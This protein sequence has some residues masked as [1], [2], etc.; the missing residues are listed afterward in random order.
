MKTYILSLLLS[1]LV[2]SI[3][4]AQ[5][6]KTANLMPVPQKVEWQGGKFRLKSDFELSVG[7]TYNPRLK[8]GA[9][10]FLRDLDKKTG[11]FFQQG[12]LSQDDLGKSTVFEISSGEVGEVNI[13]MKEDYLLEVTQNKITL[14][15]PTDIGAL[16]GLE[17]LLQLVSTDAEGYFFPTVKIDDKPRFKWRGLMIDVSRHFMPIQTIKRNIDLMAAVKLNV[18][19]W[20]L[21]DDQGFRIEVKAFPKL[22]ELGADG[23]YYT[24]EELKEIVAY[25]D[26]RGIRVVPEVD[27]P[28]HATTFAV[29]YPE[30][31]SSPHQYIHKKE[32]GLEGDSNKVKQYHIERN[33]G[34]F[35]AT[36]DPTN[37]KTYEILFALFEEMAEIFPDEYVHIGGDENEGKQ[38][39]SNKEIQKFMIEKGLKDN[40]DLQNHFNKK[41]LKKLQS[42]GKIMMGWD[43]I[44]QPDLP[45][46]AVIQSWRGKESLYKAASQGYQAVLSN[47]YYIDLMHSAE[48][49]YLNDP[50]SKAESLSDE[51]K[52][53]ILGG[54]ATMW[55]EHI[56]PHTI[57]SRIWPRMAAIAERY[58]SAAS[59]NDVNDMYR[60]LATIELFLESKG[61]THRAYQQR[62]IRELANGGNTEP[63]EVL[64]GVTNPLRFYTRNPGGTYYQTFYPFNKFVDAATT[65]AKTARNFDLLT[66]QYLT[67]PPL[68]EEVV[69]YLEMWK[70]NHSKFIELSKSS[71]VLREMDMLSQNLSESASVVLEAM[72]KGRSR[73]DEWYNSAIETLEE[74]REQGGR[75]EL[76]ILGSLERVL[77]H[78]TTTIYASET[79]G[80]IK[81]DGDLND[82][83]D[84]AFSH[85]LPKDR[86]SNDSSFYALQW[87]KK[88][89]YMAFRV[90]N[91]KLLAQHKERDAIGLHTDD[92]IEFLI[93]PNNDRNN[94]W[95][96]DDIAYHVNILNQ[97][98]DEKGND[99]E[100][101]NRSWN[102][103]VKSA[104]KVMGTVNDISDLDQGYMVELAI[105]WEEL[106]VLPTKELVMGI[107]LCVNGKT[108][109]AKDIY[110]YYDLMQLPVFHVPSGYAELKLK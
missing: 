76:V 1:I 11:L 83:N 77:K 82:W 95:K 74:A 47:G 87:D 56:K 89:L 90:K 67:N 8:K 93:D 18:F 108:D 94:D 102:G 75:A 4:N 20:H 41:L 19:H 13:S 64:V 14:N 27:V 92:G 45:K 97:L 22:H 88:N 31:A 85:F 17:T 59:V 52:S 50:L 9:E 21:T 43:E 6:E 98:L 106:G 5:I 33:T 96:E 29:A 2:L 28:G 35:D 63:I 26:E 62:L 15:A 51:A 101:F 107:N 84:V 72:E 24:H 70:A 40:H 68:K 46:E 3:S 104:V 55:S 39:D 60:R 73:S 91:Y 23:D 99:S 48:H 34:I 57:D 42:L 10:R 16:R 7:G 100:G 61:S 30:I 44:L 12:F 66:Q 32:N 78:H 49:H 80:R 25:A 54:E 58:W 71:P 69:K 38:W 103:N 65:D 36:L 81:I 37:D 105:S 109:D 53:K 79:N 86:Y 110:Y